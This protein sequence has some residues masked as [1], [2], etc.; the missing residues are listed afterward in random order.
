MYNKNIF[1]YLIYTKFELVLCFFEFKYYSH[2]QSR[3]LLL[4]VIGKQPLVAMLRPFVN[5]ISAFIGVLLSGSLYSLR[6]K[7]NV[8]F[9]NTHRLKNV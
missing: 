4:I 7:M 9:K 3:I 1:H 5:I 8:H 2:F 6:N